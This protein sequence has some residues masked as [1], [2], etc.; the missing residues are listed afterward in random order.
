[1]L[2]PNLHRLRNPTLIHGSLIRARAPI[3]LNPSFQSPQPIQPI[4]RREREIAYM[5]STS[6]STLAMAFLSM[7]GNRAP[8][9][10]RD[11]VAQRERRV[12]GRGV[13]FE[14]PEFEGP[15]EG[16][17][18]TRQA[19]VIATPGSTSVQTMAVVPESGMTEKG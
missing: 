17:M 1:M 2:N 18:V 5:A 14:A 9:A 3:P 19:A 6:T 11:V 4:Q 15:E 8:V 7:R 10:T 12:L 13:T 16:R